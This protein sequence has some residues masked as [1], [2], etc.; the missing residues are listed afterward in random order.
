MDT[1]VVLLNLG[2]PATPEREAAVDSLERIFQVNADLES[3]DSEETARELAKRLADRTAGV[4]TP[5][6]T[7]RPAADD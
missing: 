6:V 3:A 1:G 5:V 7:E 2:E 4:D